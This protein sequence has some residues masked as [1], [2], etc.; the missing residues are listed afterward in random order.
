MDA[1]AKDP[2]TVRADLLVELGTVHGAAMSSN[3]RLGWVIVTAP[4]SAQVL[5]LPARF[6]QRLTVETTGSG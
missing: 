6:D 4:G 3:D 2:A 1:I 5:E